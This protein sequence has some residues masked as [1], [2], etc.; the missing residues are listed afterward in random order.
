MK[1]EGRRKLGLSARIKFCNRTYSSFYLLL[2]FEPSDRN[3]NPLFWQE[4][5]NF[6]CHKYSSFAMYFFV[7]KKCISS[8]FRIIFC[9]QPFSSIR[10]FSLS[11]PFFSNSYLYNLQSIFSSYCINIFPSF[12][13]LLPECSR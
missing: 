6:C 13:Q 10:P 5:I 8:V 1:R 9:N 11:D 7:Q 3:V 12:I 2:C 4:Y